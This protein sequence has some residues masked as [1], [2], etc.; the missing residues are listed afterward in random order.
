MWRWPKRVPDIRTLLAVLGLLF[1]AVLRTA[2][3]VFY[4]KFG[5]SPDDLGL[6][7]VELLVQS[8]VGTSVL[9]LVGLVT[10]FFVLAEYVGLGEYLRELPKTFKGR[11]EEAPATAATTLF[12]SLVAVA[13]AAAGAIGL[14]DLSSA[15]LTVTVWVLVAWMMI[16][17]VVTIKGGVSGKGVR[18]HA[19]VRR[20]RLVLAVAL[21][22]TV[23]LAI[24]ALIARAQSDAKRVF[25]GHPASLTV[26]GVRVTSWGAEEATVS[27]TSTQVAADLRPLAGRC[28]LYFGQSGGTNF[29]YDAATHELVRIPTAVSAVRIR[30]PSCNG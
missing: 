14:H 18:D 19:R 26:L 27:W 23:G 7:Y 24:A 16:R 30:P 25:A 4:N 5:L 29:L 11:A 12:V 6:G 21:F 2:Y 13:S 15:L 8:A 28:L 17:G 1:Y 10:A 9:L 20:W 3:S 22:A